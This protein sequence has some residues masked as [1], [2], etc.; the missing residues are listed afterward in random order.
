MLKM[1]SLPN[2]S[3]PERRSPHTPQRTLQLSDPIFDPHRDVVY[4]NPVHSKLKT[5]I[6]HHRYAQAIALLEQQSPDGNHNFQAHYT[7]ACLHARLSQYPPATHHCYQALELKHRSELPCYLLAQ[8]ALIQ[9]EPDEAKRILHQILF[10][11]NE[12]ALAYYDLAQLY[13]LDNDGDRAQSLEQKA[14]ELLQDHD[15]DEV[16]DPFRQC[17]VQQLYD[18]IN[19]RQAL[20]S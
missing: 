4:Q 20:I 15:L 18:E 16:L 9:G 3:N 13:Y 7:L 10:F 17:T 19:D 12:A 6:R 2:F 11:N 14:F 1:V 5:L 8:M